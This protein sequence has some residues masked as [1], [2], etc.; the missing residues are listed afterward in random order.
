MEARAGLRPY[1]VSIIRARASSGARRG[2]GPTEIVHEFPILPTPKLGDMT[3]LQEILS[4]DQ[5]RETGAILLSGIS[6]EYTED[7][8]LG[9]GPNGDPIPN[10]EVVFWEIRFLDRGGNV[11]QRRRFV[12]SS[13]PN[14][15]PERAQWTISLTRAPADRR[16]DGVLR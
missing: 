14:P 5:L 16:R 11:T 9:R 3:G 12:A 13:A 1:A 15:D 4:P 7:Q 6:L 10:G 2:D 8:L